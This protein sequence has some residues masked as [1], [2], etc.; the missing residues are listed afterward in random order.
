MN[1]HSNVNVPL[2]LQCVF[3]F[4]SY[5]APYIPNEDE[6]KNPALY[7]KN[8]RLG[9]LDSMGT[10]MIGT[11]HGFEDYLMF[12]KA[13]MANTGFDTSNV[14]MEDVLNTAVT[15]SLFLWCEIGFCETA[16]FNNS[17]GTD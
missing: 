13:N 2:C 15:H 3:C 9:L 10:K 7:G 8:V 1:V 12:R 5:I 11:S 14:V 16:Y 6:R 17:F 4:A